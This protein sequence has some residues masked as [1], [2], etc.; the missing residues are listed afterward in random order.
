MVVFKPCDPQQTQAIFSE[1]GFFYDAA[2]CCAYF[3]ELGGENYYCLFTAAN[4]RAELIDLDFGAGNVIAE[5]LLRASLNFAAGRS[6]YIAICRRAEFSEFLLRFHF[7]WE[8]D[9]LCGEIPEILTGS[10]HCCHPE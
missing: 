9:V 7:R 6:A 4:A 3:I 5:G 1:R 8:G 2:Q 10:C